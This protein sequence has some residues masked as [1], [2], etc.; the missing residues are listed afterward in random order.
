MYFGN[1][2]FFDYSTGIFGFVILLY[3]FKF[4]TLSNHCHVFWYIK[5]Y[6]YCLDITKNRIIKTHICLQSFYK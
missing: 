6:L 1:V 2:E 3:F 4:F 5:V